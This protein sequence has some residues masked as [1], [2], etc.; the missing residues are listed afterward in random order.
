MTRLRRTFE[1]HKRGWMMTMIIM[2]VVLKETMV[3]MT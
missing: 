2:E 3:T 1:G